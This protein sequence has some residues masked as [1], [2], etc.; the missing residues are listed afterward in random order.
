MRERKV[1]ALNTAVDRN[2]PGRLM[3]APRP[4]QAGY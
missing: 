4:A 1:I 3:A 2:N